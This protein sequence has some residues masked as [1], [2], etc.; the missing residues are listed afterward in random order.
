M[1]VYTVTSL[2]LRG[3]G[4]VQALAG[5]MSVSEEMEEETRGIQEIER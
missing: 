1:I 3:A 2:F 4:S 5:T